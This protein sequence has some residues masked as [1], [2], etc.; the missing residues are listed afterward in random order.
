[1]ERDD[2]TKEDEASETRDGDSSDDES[3]DGEGQSAWDEYTSDKKC[4]ECDEPIID[5]RAACPNCGY[6]YKDEDYNDAEAGKEFV[7]GSA[8]DEEGNEMPEDETG[9]AGEE[10]EDAGLQDTDGGGEDAAGEED[11]DDA[12]SESKRDEA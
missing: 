10:S 11:A 4:P 3:K 8:I 2:S 7:S 6:E 9:G 5:V 1:M 12:E